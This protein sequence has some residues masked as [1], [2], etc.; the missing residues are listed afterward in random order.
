[1]IFPPRVYQNNATKE[2]L[3]YTFTGAEWLVGPDFR[4]PHAGE[5]FVQL[6]IVK[7]AV[8]KMYTFLSIIVAL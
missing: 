3:Y 7:I 8:E 5:A 4:K 6:T 2:H 1:M